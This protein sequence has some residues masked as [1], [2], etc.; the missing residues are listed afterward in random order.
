MTKK[1]CNHIRRMGLP[2]VVLSHE[3]CTGNITMSISTD[4]FILSFDPTQVGSM[5]LRDPGSPWGMIPKMSGISTR[6]W[7]MKD[8]ADFITNCISKYHAHSLYP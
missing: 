3:F 7:Y 6:G 2:A 5:Y 4:L 8:Y 1:Q